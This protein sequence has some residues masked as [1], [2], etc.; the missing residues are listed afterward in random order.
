MLPAECRRSFKSTLAVGAEECASV[1]GDRL[2]RPKGSRGTPAVCTDMNRWNDLVA[3]AREIDAA[4]IGGAAIAPDK[5]CRLALMVLTL[6]QPPGDTNGHA[7]A[8]PREPQP[9]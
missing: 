4:V 1:S 9:S 7:A 6:T 8:G 3:L 5:V 2:A